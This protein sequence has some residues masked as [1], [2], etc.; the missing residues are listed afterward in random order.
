MLDT[1]RDTQSGTTPRVIWALG[2]GKK[3][4]TTNRNLLRASFDSPEQISII[5]RESPVIDIDFIKDNRTFS[6]HPEI[7]KLRLDKW[8][9]NFIDD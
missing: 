6:I 3:I 8:V 5:D 1:D 7:E 2:V 9:K 4:I